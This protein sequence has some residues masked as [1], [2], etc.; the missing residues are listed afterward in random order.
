MSLTPHN[1]SIAIN[2]RW[3][4]AIL[5]P[6]R[7]SEN[8][9]GLAK[10][11]PVEIMVPIDGLSPYQIK[12]KNIIFIPYEN[13]LQI[14]ILKTDSETLS[15]ALN[16]AIKVLEWLPVTPTSA[17]GFNINYITNSIGDVPVE[18][19]EN[20]YLD[21][22]LSDMGFSIVKRQTYRTFSYEKG[23]INIIA[24]AASDS[25]EIT[26]NFHKETASNTDAIEWLKIS[27]SEVISLVQKILNK[28][29]LVYEEEI[30]S[31]ESKPVEAG[32]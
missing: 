1:W 19:L 2:G 27:P 13:R 12:H 22:N 4:L 16:T 17:V 5:T 20:K 10:G 8:V 26:F 14:S 9:F 24:K 29:K 23:I 28:F 31:N 6:G 25:F 18:I 7:I 30:K 15:Y 21:N 11:T 3:N 32:K